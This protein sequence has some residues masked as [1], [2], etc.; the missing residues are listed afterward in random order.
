MVSGEM[1][2]VCSTLNVYMKTFLFSVSSKE[3]LEMKEFIKIFRPFL[4]ASTSYLEH[5]RGP[6]PSSSTPLHLGFVHHRAALFLADLIQ[7]VVGLKE[8]DKS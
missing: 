4:G 1:F 8:E 5:I 3:K 6:A 2:T 7:N